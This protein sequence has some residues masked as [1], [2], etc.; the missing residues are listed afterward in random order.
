MEFFG[1]QICFQV[2]LRQRLLAKVPQRMRVL[3]EFDFEEQRVH[4]DRIA[5]VVGFTVV[6]CLVPLDWPVRVVM[7]TVGLISSY[8][9]SF[10][11]VMTK[12]PVFSIHFHYLNK[13]E[14]R[15][16]F[17]SLYHFTDS[18]LVHCCSLKGQKTNTYWMALPRL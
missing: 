18:M 7:W 15:N 10:F 16:R 8:L 6:V 2:E 3:P 1:R 5:G 14:R 17:Q 11:L 4:W 9:L 12:N 13:L